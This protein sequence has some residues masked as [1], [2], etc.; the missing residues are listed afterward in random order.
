MVHGEGVRGW[1]ALRGG[2]AGPPGGA[3]DGRRQ[4]DGGAQ[5]TI[6]VLVGRGRIGLAAPSTRPT[7][8]A[9]GGPG[10]TSTPTGSAAPRRRAKRSPASLRTGAL[11]SPPAAPRRT[12]SS[13]PSAAWPSRTGPSRCPH[14]PHGSVS[15]WPSRRCA[16]CS[17]RRCRRGSSWGMA[18]AARGWRRTGVLASDG[19]RDVW[20]RAAVLG[21]GLGRKEVHG[22][23]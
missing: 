23:R 2:A 12:P 15:C 3:G 6:V 17:R 4:L 14:G 1:G 20:R 22:G 9:R 13:A 19:G 8:T 18:V 10:A 11:S 5:W 21:G 7:S 16:R